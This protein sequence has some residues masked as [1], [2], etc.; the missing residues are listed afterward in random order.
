MYDGKNV[1]IVM[2]LLNSLA[3][4]YC[5]IFQGYSYENDEGPVMC[6]NGP[7]TYQLGWYCNMQTAKNKRKLISEV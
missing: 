1:E 6:F 3:Q 2:Q 7:K 4:P 5:E